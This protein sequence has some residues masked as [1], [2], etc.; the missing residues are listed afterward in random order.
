[1]TDPFREYDAPRTDDPAMRG[2]WLRRFLWPNA[3]DNHLIA[4]LGADPLDW[5]AFASIDT[6][7]LLGA[8]T[9]CEHLG[10]DR[11]QGHSIGNAVV[12]D[13]KRVAREIVER[14]TARVWR[15]AASRT[16]GEQIIGA[17]Q[18]ELNRDDAFVP[19]E[20]LIPACRRIAH[21]AANRRPRGASRR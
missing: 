9:V 17:A 2:A 21:T 5:G 11:R 12:R 4:A 18:A 14:V 6:D 15:L 20:V 3:R 19:D 16:P 1:M 13:A 10:W 7:P 8:C